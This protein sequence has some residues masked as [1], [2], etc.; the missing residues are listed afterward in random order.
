MKLAID[1]VNTSLGSGTKTYNL[2]LIKQITKL[3]IKDIVY[4]FI[5][6]N[7]FEEINTDKIN[8]KKIK[9]IIKSNFFSNSFLRIIWMQI[10]FPFELKLRKID[11]LF[12]PMNICPIMIKLFNIKIYLALHSNLPWK[13]FH[14]MP[15]NLIKRY[16]TK[17]LMEWSITCCDTLLVDSFF[18]KKEIIGFLKINKKKIK[19]IYLGCKKEKKIAKKY[20]PNYFL[21]VL[22]CVRYHNIINLLKA[23]KYISQRYNINFYLVTQVLDKDYYLEIKKFIKEHKLRNKVKIF[24]DLPSYRLPKLYK[25]SKFYIFTSYCEVFGLTTL[26]AMSYDCPILVANRSALPEINS[27][28]AEYF[29]PDDV[30]QIKRKMLKMI[31]DKKLRKKLKN[32]SKIHLK[33]FSWTKTAIQTLKILH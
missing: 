14:F 16:L 29:N 17:K 1:F 28:A 30:A 22:S 20:S 25:N 7:Y 2:N 13:Y 11:K 5:T 27:N 12:S 26:E 18:A 23:F 6:K 9:F 31:N 33:K 10:I 15:G 21:S 32:N 8:N 4:I 19:V 24:K 3:K